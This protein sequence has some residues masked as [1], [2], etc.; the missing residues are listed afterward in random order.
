MFIVDQIPVHQIKQGD[1][2]K[3]RDIASGKDRF[4]TVLATMSPYVE[5]QLE[6]TT[7]DG[8]QICTSKTH[9]IAIVRDKKETYIET[10]ELSLGDLIITTNGY[11]LVESISS[12]DYNKIFT[13]FTVDED[14]NYYAGNQANKLILAHNSATVHFP[15]WHYEFEELIVLKNNKGTDQN[16]IRQMDYCFLFNRLMYKRLVE[17]K[18]IT[19][20]SPNDVPGLLNAFY[21][22]Q[23]EF[24]RLY[25][26][27]EADNTIRKR[28]LKAIDVFVMFLTERKETGRIYLMNIDHANS[29]GSFLPEFAPITQ[30]NL[31]LTGDTVVRALIDGNDTTLELSSLVEKFNRGHDIQV[32]S[33]NLSLEKNQFNKVS[34]AAM[35]GSDLEVMKITDVETGFFIT[36][37]PEHQVY[38]QNRGYIKAKELVETDILSVIR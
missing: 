37:T 24:E 14:N 13:D 15:L 3:C 4:R 9:P 28:S 20:F 34:N 27:Y 26:K 35:T 12:A 18:D 31:C 30:S 23:D 29:H 17:G 38:T 5:D 11:Q 10:H 6:I 7:V 16:R 2:I 1:L 25:A 21:A 33:R 22:D 8:Y 32:W 19:F 36:C